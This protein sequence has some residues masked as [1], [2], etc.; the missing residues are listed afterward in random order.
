[1]KVEPIILAMTSAL[2]LLLLNETLLL[3]LHAA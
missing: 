3:P 2:Q 1:V